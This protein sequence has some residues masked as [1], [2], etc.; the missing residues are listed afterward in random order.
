MN[1]IHYVVFCFDLQTSLNVKRN[2]KS[3]MILNF[4]MEDFFKFT[5]LSHN[6]NKRCEKNI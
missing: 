1:K 6:R 5:A 4:S 2:K 3:S